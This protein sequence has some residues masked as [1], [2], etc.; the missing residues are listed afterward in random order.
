MHYDRATMHAA[1]AGLLNEQRLAILATVSQQSPYCNLVS[2]TPSEDLRAILFSTPRATSK[3]ANMLR[4]PNVSLLVDDRMRS[5]F[6]FASGMVVTAIGTVEIAG[7]QDEDGLKGRHAERHADL[8]DFIF[9][10]DC[11]LVQVRVA[12]YILV[13]SLHEASVL[14]INS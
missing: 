13:S 4:N 8:K 12:R 9:S 14:E 1:I 5:G 10:P 2:F 7:P 11:A 3:Y 6:G